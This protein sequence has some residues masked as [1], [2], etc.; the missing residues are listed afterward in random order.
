[1]AA[2]PPRDDKPTMKKAT[3]PAEASPFKS[4]AEELDTLRKTFRTACR[5]YAERVDMEI[6][7]LRERVVAA[8]ETHRENDKVKLA[9]GS[10]GR[11]AAP[12]RDMATQFH[13]LRDMLTV[14]RTLEVKPLAGR[15]R[16]LKK[17]EAAVED[18]R[19]LIEGWR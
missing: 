15:R 1:M 2:P 8:G 4:A 19:M 5:H 11:T 7:R 13:D 9:A 12:A 18:L 3:A 10:R 17:I 14:L 16:D 6:I